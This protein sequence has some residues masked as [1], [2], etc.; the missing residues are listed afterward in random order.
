MFARWLHGTCV[1]A[2]VQKVDNEDEPFVCS[3]FPD[4]SANPDVA[5]LVL[6]IQH[7]VRST[8]SSLTRYLLRWKR[9]RHIWK[10]DKVSVV[11]YLITM[12]QQRRF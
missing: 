3:Y 7:G 8:I 9:Y 1:E 4:I 5:S 11:I 12:G 6:Q 10:S 2:P